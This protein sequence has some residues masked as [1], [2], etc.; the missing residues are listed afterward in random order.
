MY[1]KISSIWRPQPPY[2]KQPLFVLSLWKSFYWNVSFKLKHMTFLHVSWKKPL[3]RG[4]LCMC[5]CLFKI[6]IHADSLGKD[7][8]QC[9]WSDNCITCILYHELS[10]CR[11][12]PKWST[13]RNFLCE[14]LTY[15]SASHWPLELCLP[16]S[17]IINND[18]TPYKGSCDGPVCWTNYYTTALDIPP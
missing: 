17:C 13:F 9:L 16:T 7:F 4:S 14:R 10:E 2:V 5:V 15:E 6:P 1:A 11:N 18:A 8:Y 12:F 3:K